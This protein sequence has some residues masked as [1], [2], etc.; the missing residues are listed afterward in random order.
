MSKY[1]YLI[2]VV[3]AGL[4]AACWIDRKYY[5]AR[6]NRRIDREIGNA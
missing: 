2:L 1:D 6:I 3:M 5:W 4:V